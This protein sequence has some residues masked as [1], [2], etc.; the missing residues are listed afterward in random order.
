MIEWATLIVTVLGLGGLFLQ[1]RAAS[2]G[3]ERDHVRQKKQATLDAYVGSLDFRNTV[4]S[5]LPNDRQIDAVRAFCPDPEDDKHPNF[6]PIVHYLN[7]LENIA[8]GVHESIYDLNV[9]S[10]L[11]GERI[12][13]AWHAYE[14]FIVG[15]RAVFGSKTL[16]VE[17]EHL[18][19]AIKAALTEPANASSSP[20]SR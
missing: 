8:V 15:R 18:A 9:V 16:W 5:K 3:Q 17:F 2:I 19:I 1:I 7:Y 14:P 20:G 10:R 12:V 6:E 4:W 13:C 11:L